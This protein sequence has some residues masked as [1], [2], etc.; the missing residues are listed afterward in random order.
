MYVC[1]G[2]VLAGELVSWNMQGHHKY[3][4][5]NHQG[6][7]QTVPGFHASGGHHAFFLLTKLQS[8]VVKL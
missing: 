8:P 5:V 4:R 6:R 7:K 2:K 1:H 3:T